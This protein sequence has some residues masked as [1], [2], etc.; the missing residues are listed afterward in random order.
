LGRSRGKEG[1]REEQREGREYARSR[2][3]R[4]RAGIG[5][6]QREKR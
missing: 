1:N 3:N 5:E 6:E 2:G 4:G